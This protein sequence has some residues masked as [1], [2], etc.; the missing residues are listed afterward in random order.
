MSTHFSLSATVAHSSGVTRMR[1]TAAM[2]TCALEGFI[3]KVRPR[4]GGG[5]GPKLDIKEVLRT[6]E[7]GIGRRGSKN[8]ILLRTY[9]VGGPFRYSACRVWTC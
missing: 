5:V 8:P 2:Q 3:C 4:C 1:Q 7:R 6:A 9:M